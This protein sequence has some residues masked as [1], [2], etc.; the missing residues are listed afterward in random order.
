MADRHLII[1]ATRCM[2]MRSSVRARVGQE[3]QAHFGRIHDSML[4][5]ARGRSTGTIAIL[6]D[7]TKR[8]EEIRAMKHQ[9]AARA[10]DPVPT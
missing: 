4:K 7:V 3:R 10:N 6:R 5:D 9:L 1:L 8:F 2:K